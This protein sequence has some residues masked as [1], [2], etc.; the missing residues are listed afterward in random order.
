[1]YLSD[2]ENMFRGDWVFLYDKNERF[3]DDDT[4]ITNYL[5]KHY[6]DYEIL[7]MTLNESVK[8]TFI[9]IMID[10]QKDNRDY[11]SDDI[12]ECCINEREYQKDYDKMEY[13]H[14]VY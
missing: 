4:G 8:K 9:Y 14:D 13:G 3:I 6:G 11:D 2:L 1:M 12:D 7:D 10:Y 5:I